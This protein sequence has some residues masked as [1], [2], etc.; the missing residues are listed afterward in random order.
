MTQLCNGWGLVVKVDSDR[1]GAASQ[2][3][4]K[5]QKKDQEYYGTCS[6]QYG[7]AHSVWF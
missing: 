6:E 3:D 2:Y 1:H 7:F 4:E 5:N